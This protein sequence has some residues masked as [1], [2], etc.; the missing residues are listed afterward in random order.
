MWRRQAEKSDKEMCGRRRSQNGTA[1]GFENERTTTR[2]MRWSPEA[3]W[4]RKCLSA[5]PEAAS[6][7]LPA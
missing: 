5:L 7:W 2:R 1:A 3:A 4:G 6:A